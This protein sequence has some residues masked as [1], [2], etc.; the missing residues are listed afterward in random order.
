MIRQAIA[1]R[2]LLCIFALGFLA[3]DEIVL[4]SLSEFEANRTIVKLSLAGV[5]A[6]K[7]R[8]GSAWN[9]RVGK[10]DYRQAL[11]LVSSQRSKA[12]RTGGRAT[13]HK[14]LVYSREERE[15]FIEHMTHPIGTATWP[16]PL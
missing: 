7:S 5:P 15:Y 1:T 11:L 12:E 3:C 10:S 2:F 14:S 13:P 16:R 6:K 4:H 9:V 8:D